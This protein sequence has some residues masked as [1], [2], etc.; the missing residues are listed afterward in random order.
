MTTLP[1]EPL[2]TPARD[3]ASMRGGSAGALRGRN[4]GDRS[5]RAVLTALALVLPLLLL[6]LLTELA[7]SAAPAIA[8]FG[9]RFLWSSTWDPVAQ[10]FGARNLHVWSSY[11]GEDPE[12]NYSTGNS[13]SDLLTAGPPTVFTV[14]LNLKY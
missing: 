10:V 6:T 9:P 13:Q 12:A 1:I 5:Y 14:H 3:D 8:R 4:A 11:T 7:L 2:P